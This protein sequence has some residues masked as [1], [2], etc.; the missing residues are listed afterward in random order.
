MPFPED[1]V[2]VS[3]IP[4]MAKRTVFAAAQDDSKPLMKCVNLKFTKDGLRAAVGNGSCIVT[5]KGDDK[6]TGDVSLLVPAFSLEKLVRLCGDKDEFRV[7]TTGKAIVFLKENFAFSARLLEGDYINVEGLIGSIRNQFTVLSGVEELRKALDTASCVDSDGKVCLRFEGQRLTFHCKSENGNTA[8]PLD[9]IPLTGMPQGEYWY[10]SKQLQL[11]KTR[12][13]K[14]ELEQRPTELRDTIAAILNEPVDQLRSAVRFH[15]REAEPG[16]GWEVVTDHCCLGGCDLSVYDFPS[17]RD[18]L[19]FARLLDIVG[20]RP[21][22][23]I[24]C[25]ACYE[26]H[27][28]QISDSGSFPA[29]LTLGSPP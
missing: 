8:I 21:S 28:K 17:E 16:P 4:G 29:V 20:Y 13:D 5:A 7:G 26:E 2:K 14:F 3:G 19:L 23:N 27:M 9:V 12:A 24:A 6:S 15:V 25:P 18:A 11:A 1:T 10:I 22:H